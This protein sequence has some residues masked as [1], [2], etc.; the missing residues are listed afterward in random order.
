MDEARSE[1]AVDAILLARSRAGDRPA[2][3]SLYDRHAGAAFSLAAR[4]VGPALAADVVHDAFLALL[5]RTATFDPGRGRFR[6]WFMTSVHHRCLNV[7][8]KGKPM[9]GPDGLLDVPDAGPDPADL[10]VQRMRSGS[11][12]N[13]LQRLP[14]EQRRLIV[15]AYYEGWS[16]SELAVRLGLPLG[17]VKA[18]MR[19]G[20]IALRGLLRGDAA[21]GGEERYS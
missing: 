16:Q 11:V 6:A 1:D 5:E 3:S 17:T 13:A 15:L 2:F 7:L 9:K 21:T 8:R 12:R 4:I 19:R 20:L 10:L 18:R 14:E